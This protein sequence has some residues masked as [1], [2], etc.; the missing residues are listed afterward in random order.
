MTTTPTEI[1]LSQLPINTEAEIVSLAEHSLQTKLLEMGLLVGKV[2]KMHRPAP[3]GDP[4]MIEV[5]NY[6]LML[7]KQEA[8]LITVRPL[9]TT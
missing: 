9:F 6:R 3:F 5:S 1:P 8:G 2:V 7:R 4:L